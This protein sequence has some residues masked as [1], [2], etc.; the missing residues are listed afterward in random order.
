MWTTRNMYCI[1]L[2][3]LT[4]SPLSEITTAGKTD[5]LPHLHITLL[6]TYSLPLQRCNKPLLIKIL[7]TSERMEC[8]YKAKMWSGTLQIK[9]WNLHA[10]GLSNII[11]NSYFTFK[12][13]W[14]HIFEIDIGRPLNLRFC[15][16]SGAP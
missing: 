3:F 5:S 15:N 1:S 14:Q 4:F 13:T 9:W 2:G 10:K 12:Q 11:K 16:Q 7:W 8:N 6:S